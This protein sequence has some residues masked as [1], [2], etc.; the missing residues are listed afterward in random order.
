MIKVKKKR[1]IYDR[2]SGICDLIPNRHPLMLSD[3][4]RTWQQNSLPTETRMRFTG[5]E[6]THTSR[7]CVKCRDARR[8]NA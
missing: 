8:C 2:G 4:L 6:F 7:T 5:M 1:K 3:V